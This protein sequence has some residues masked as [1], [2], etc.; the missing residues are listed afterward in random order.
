V[1]VVQEAQLLQMDLVMLCVRWNLV[2]CC[3]TVWKIAF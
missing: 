2:N 1:T 3:T